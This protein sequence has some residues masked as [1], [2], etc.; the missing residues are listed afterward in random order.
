MAGIVGALIVVVLGHRAPRMFSMLLGTALSIAAMILLIDG[1]G[2]SRFLIAAALF[3]FAWN[4]TFPYQMGVLSSLDRTGAV[5]ISSLIVQ[6]ASLSLGPLI[7]AA[8]SPGSGYTA[9]LIACVGCYVVSLAMFR[10]ST[11]L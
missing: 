2:Y 8:L 1:T 4:Y 7:A 5:A 11:R 9:I 10:T 6:L 3:N